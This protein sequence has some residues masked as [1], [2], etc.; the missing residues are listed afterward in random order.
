[1]K[2][3]PEL[4]AILPE[5]DPSS[6]PAPLPFVAQRSGGYIVFASRGRA[7]AIPS[8]EIQELSFAHSDLHAQV[9]VLLRGGLA[10]TVDGDLEK[11]RALFHGLLDGIVGTISESAGFAITPP[12]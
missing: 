2:F 10:W 6:R 3:C 12:A 8:Y 9:I 4:T 1:M 11:V 7:V 5:R